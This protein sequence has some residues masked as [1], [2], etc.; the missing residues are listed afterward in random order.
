MASSNTNRKKTT[1]NDRRNIWLLVLTTILMVA[2]IWAFMPPQE[3]INQGLDIQ[4][5]LSVVLTASK[6][7]GGAISDEDMETSRQIIESRVNA[8]GASEAVV[9]VQGT[10]QILVQ[11][12]GLSDT[13]T[14]LDTIG[15]TGKLEFARLDS[16]TDENTVNDIKSGNYGKEGTVTDAFG[17]T[18]STGKEEHLKVEDGTYTPI[19]TGDNIERV[20]VDRASEGSPYYAVNIKLDAEGTQAFADASRAL[21]AD[22]GQI[23]IILDNEVQSAPAVQSEIPNGEVQITGNYTNEEAHSLQTVLDSGS[24]PVSFEYSQSQVVGPTLGQ[25]ALR[26]GVLVAL[27]GIL[28]VMIYLLF[29]YKGLGT[30]TAGA[31]IVFAV[32]YLGILAGLSAFGLFSLTLSGIAGIVLT[33]GMAADSSVLTVERFREE[34]RMG[35]SVRA[36]SITGVRHAIQTSIDAD[37]VS[38]VSAL[39][40]FFLASA[41]VKGFGLTLSLGILCDI[42]MML[43]FKAPLIRLLAPRAIA[44]HPGFWNVKD[45]QIAAEKFAALGAIE[46]VTA[47]EAE[48]GEALDSEETDRVVRSRAGESGMAVA[49]AVHKLKG[50][51]IKH[52]IDFVGKRKIFLIIS[53]VLLVASF[54]VIGLKG[55]TFGIEFVGGTSVSFHDTGDVTID[56]MRSAFSNAG[57]PD[58]TIQTAT[59]DGQEGFLARMTITDAQEASTVANKVASELGLS[60][61]NFEVTTIGPDWGASVIQ[62]SLIAF[63]VSLVLIIIYI[64][65]RFEFKMGVTAVVVLLHDLII[66]VGIYALVGREFTPN[67]VAA[68]LT[69]IGYSLYDTVVVFHRINDNAK[70]LNIKCSFYT[71]ANHS[72]NQVF[73]RSINTTL[74]SLIPVVGM[75]LF[76]GETL[77]DFAFAMTIGLIIGCYSSIAVGTP[78]Y[79][80]WKTREPKYAKLEQKY[81]PKIGT[82]EFERSGAVIAG[83]IGKSKAARI[84]TARVQAA[85]AEAALAQ[86]GAS[87]TV[88][89]SGGGEGAPVADAIDADVE[90]TVSGSESNAIGP[91]GKPVYQ[92]VVHNPKKRKK[93]R[94]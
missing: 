93:K 27:L 42:A 16:F 74:T 3:K 52:D 26:S 7:D 22:H 84:K 56:D 31:V 33:I 20:T 5:G 32:L 8:L 24:L 9:Q 90:V 65:I 80:I 40:L 72:L 47:G 46:G 51:F 54:G 18:F 59:S 28:L 58:A 57:A 44:K 86:S 87:S 53:A 78:L 71:M 48:I 91:D 45:G 38:L 76:G 10:N 62:Q 36:A 60:T 19:V 77:K 61:D 43:L 17:N 1:G 34:V 73:I 67:A 4:G 89:A 88:D 82:F 70:D 83:N 81:G 2:S 79:S 11:I 30:I 66:V 29:F 49:E 15:K 25:D 13:Q 6:T 12:P 39:C 63:L 68:L 92:Q 21:V 55:M 23:V 14:A 75:L 64:A 41:S 69:I 85:N 50:R 37:L 35:R 94:K